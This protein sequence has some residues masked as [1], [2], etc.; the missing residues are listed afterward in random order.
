MVM[1]DVMIIVRVPSVAHQRICDVGKQRIKPRVLPS[2]N[3]SHV[4]VLVHHESICSHVIGLHDPVK[5]SMDP[6]EVVKQ[7]NG[8]WNGCSKVQEE[9]R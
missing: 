9:M 5:N 6:I 8:A 3:S 4:N 1:F 2:K 7:K